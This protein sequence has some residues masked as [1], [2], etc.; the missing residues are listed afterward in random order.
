MIC[1][2]KIIFEFLDKTEKLKRNIINIL[3]N[4]GLGYL[5]TQ[6]E[7]LDK[8]FILYYD[9]RVRELPYRQIKKYNNI[10]NE[11][12]KYLKCFSIEGNSNIEDTEKEVKIKQISQLKIDALLSR[13]LDTIDDI[14]LEILLR[15]AIL[16]S[17]DFSLS[18]K[19]LDSYGI[20]DNLEPLRKLFLPD[21]K[22]NEAQIGNIIEILKDVN[23]LILLKHLIHLITQKSG[24]EQ[25]EIYKRFKITKG[26]EIFSS[27]FLNFLW[28]SDDAN[29]LVRLE[30]F[31]KNYILGENIY[32]DVME[33]ARNNPVD[34]K[35]QL[36]FKINSFKID[37][38][39]PEVSK[40]LT[41]YIEKFREINLKIFKMVLLAELKKL[42]IEHD[43]LLISYSYEAEDI[44]KLR[45]DKVYYD[46]IKKLYDDKF[47]Q[48]R[49]ATKSGEIRACIIFRGNCLFN[50]NKVNFDW[51][52]RFEVRDKNHRKIECRIIRNRTY[53][54]ELPL[55][56]E[57]EVEIQTILI[58]KYYF[59][60]K[61]KNRRIKE[62]Y[63]EIIDIKII[64]NFRA[65][66]YYIGSINKEKMYL[67]NTKEG[68]SKFNYLEDS[69]DV[70][71]AHLPIL[72]KPIE[73]L[74]YY[75]S[76]NKNDKTSFYEVK[77]A[78]MVECMRKPELIEWLEEKNLIINEGLIKKALS[79]VLGKSIQEFNLIC[80]PMF[81]AI[82]VFE[83]DNELI[84]AY[85]SDEHKRIYGQNDV[86]ID[87]IEKIENKEMDLNGDLIEC[88]FEIIHLK[89]IHENIRLSI[90]SISGIAPFSYIIALKNRFLFPYLFLIGIHGAGKSN[91]LEVFMNF[92]YG[93]EMMNSDDSKT[94]ARLSKFLTS[95][96]FLVNVDD[97]D[98]I[99][100][101]SIA[102][103]KSYATKRDS[104]RKRMDG[105]KMNYENQYASIVG[106]ANNN[107]FLLDDEAFRIRCLVHYLNEK[108]KKTEEN[109]NDLKMYAK[110]KAEI[111]RSNK[112][113]GFYFLTIAIEFIKKQ[114]P[115]IT[116]S[117]EKLLRL[118]NDTYNDIDNY[119][120]E[121]DLDD[122]L[123]DFRRKE[124]YTFTYLGFVLWDYV[125][126]SKNKKSDLLKDLLD[127]KK[128][129]FRDYIVDL[130]KAELNINLQVFD[131]IIEF[132]ESNYNKEYVYITK[133]NIADVNSKI[134]IRTHF[135]NEY[136]KWA[137]L[138]GYETLGTIK[139]LSELQSGILNKNIFPAKYSVDNA[140]TKSGQV[141]GVIFYYKE[142]KA[143]R[144][145]SGLEE[146]DGFSFKDENEEFK[147]SNVLMD[148]FEN[149]NYDFIE[150]GIVIDVISAEL[151]EEQARIK[152]V[153]EYFIS[154]GL[155]AK[156][157]SK[158]SLE[159]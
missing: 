4:L 18:E 21:I 84:I 54:N 76:P 56:M 155:V 102:L 86:Q 105:Q 111:L 2:I 75:E 142:I 52:Q 148:F 87:V 79:L 141:F 19:D 9:V 123:T 36:P 40:E 152:T 69:K 29:T 159:E 116:S 6:Y 100:D 31:Y 97:I 90:L 32:S 131:N 118:V 157:G 136:D 96:S 5:N 92:L 17:E 38:L 133:S 50:R 58:V 106:S 156:V 34:I 39:F 43:G 26:R 59:H 20:K 158:I 124:I 99:G 112:V 24:I 49:R 12:S 28:N 93:T 128:T 85:E 146:N 126:R 48:Y 42:K 71:R 122:R 61:S 149:N 63:F 78:G 80:K 25:L 83:R 33:I 64:D 11:F 10:S 120:T 125:F 127:L 65:I 137:K 88:F 68:L 30:C 109:Q 145:D 45:V 37:K 55:E 130:E 101:G 74:N 139:K 73:L 98:K 23:D 138:R 51:S 15:N 53:F 72:A 134:L 117:Y 81:N 110:M 57:S 82:G 16:D 89:T 153:L 1:K 27:K 7:E 115:E 132:Y 113:G 60:R 67:E 144:F 140:P 103:L 151:N 119:I 66:K 14:T 104:T 3:Q 121:M 46:D 135:I 129:R 70:I 107:L 154:E 35:V 94:T 91:L 143:L 108:I 44:E 77:C 62:K 13:F 147:Y 22:I 8:L 95:T 47:E 41:R 114:Y 150:K